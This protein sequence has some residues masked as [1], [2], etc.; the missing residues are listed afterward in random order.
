MRKRATHC[1]HASTRRL[2]RAHTHT[3]PTKQNKYKYD[4]KKNG[5]VLGV[6]KT[7]P[8]AD[9]TKAYRRLA[10]RLHPDKQQHG[11]GASAEEREAS[12]A[13]FQALQR[14]YAVLGDAEKRA[15]YD[16]TGSLQDAEDVFGGGG[17]GGGGAELYARYRA[18]FR[19]VTE[20]DLVKFAVS[21]AVLSARGGGGI[22]GAQRSAPANKKRA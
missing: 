15:I 20:D 18:A 11:A 22:G 8:P 19:Q 12:R 21:G 16:E 7:A 10:L 14:I 1:A 2:N 13:S 6:A 4:N 5:Q 17:G 9:I 3:H